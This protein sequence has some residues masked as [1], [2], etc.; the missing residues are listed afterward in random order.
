MVYEVGSSVDVRCFDKRARARA[1]C[2]LVASVAVI[3]KSKTHELM[4][5]V[6]VRSLCNFGVVKLLSAGK[7]Y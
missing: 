1:V 6:T 5:F 3:G 7:F 2:R 4:L